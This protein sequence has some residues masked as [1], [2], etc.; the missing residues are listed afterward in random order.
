MFGHRRIERVSGSLS[1][2]TRR[3]SIRTSDCDG[4]FF[5]VPSWWRQTSTASSVSTRMSR[6]LQ[7]DGLR[8]DPHVPSR[9]I[10]D[11]VRLGVDLDDLGRERHEAALAVLDVQRAALVVEPD[12]VASRRPDREPPDRAFLDARVDGAVGAEQPSEDDGADGPVDPG[13]EE[14]AVRRFTIR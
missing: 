2:S 5:T 1:T 7:V 14:G 12:E 8:A 11:E 6:G 13:V 3:S 4:L 10:D 9:R